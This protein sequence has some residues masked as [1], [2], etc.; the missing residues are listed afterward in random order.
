Q[1]HFL[2]QTALIHLQFG[3]YNDNGTAR[4][5]N[6]LAQQ[7]LTE[8]AL[9]T[10]EHVGQA[11]EGTV[12]G[13]GDGTAAAAV[14]NQGV[15]SLLEHTLLVP[16]NDVGSAQLQKPLKTVVPVDDPA[17]QVVQVGG[18]ETAAVQ[19]NHGTDVQGNDRQH[20]HNHPLGTVAGQPE[21]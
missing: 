21:G 19:L 12:V 13:A 3:A 6:T 8:T 11:L 14:V 7:V 18:G 15:H 16:D 1:S 9:L 4:V 20:V 5:V 10:L 2:G 17:I